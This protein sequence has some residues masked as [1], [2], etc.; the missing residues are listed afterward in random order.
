VGICT[1]FLKRLRN[2]FVTFRP[3]LTVPPPLYA[4]T[5]AYYKIEDG[6]SQR[7]VSLSEWH[8]RRNKPGQYYRLC[9]VTSFFRW[10]TTA[11]TWLTLP[12]VK[13]N[14]CAEIR[15]TISE[16]ALI[17]DSNSMVIPCRNKLNAESVWFRQLHFSL[18]LPDFWILSNVFW[19]KNRITTEG[20]VTKQA[21]LP[22]QCLACWL[23][24]FLCW[25]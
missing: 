8:Y 14:T 25:Y 10:N 4:P 17:S 12:E 22:N 16:T 9:S 3:I 24:G 7:L 19:S 1:D 21:F 13:Y 15:V 5:N 18:G 2:I 11:L 6:L 20:L 23:L